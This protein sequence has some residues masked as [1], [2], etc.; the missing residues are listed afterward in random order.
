MTSLFKW[1]IEYWTSLAASLGGK[2]YAGLLADADSSI[3]LTF[4]LPD[5][6]T[7]EPSIPDL[8]FE[9]ILIQINKL[10]KS[11]TGVS[12]FQEVKIVLD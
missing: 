5:K 9:D 7:K 11:T 1:K 6:S 12:K 2:I 8:K 3:L 10:D 4:F